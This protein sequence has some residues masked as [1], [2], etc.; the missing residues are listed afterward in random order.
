V[1]VRKIAKDQARKTSSSNMKEIQ[2]IANIT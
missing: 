1:W 2:V